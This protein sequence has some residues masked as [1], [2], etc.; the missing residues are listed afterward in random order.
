MASSLTLSVDAM[1]GDHA[2]LAI[3]DGVEL[4]AKANPGIKIL[5]HGDEAQ[6]GPL[7]ATRPH[8]QGASQLHHAGDVVP[9]DAKPSQAMRKKGT[10]M[11]NAIASVKAGHAQAAVSAGN[12][13]ALM[14]VAHLQLRTMD[15]LHRPA[16]AAAWPSPRGQSVVLDVGANVDSDPDQLVDF[17]IMGEAFASAMLGIEKPSIGLLNIGSEDVKGH[18]D[19]KEAMRLLRLHG[20]TLGLNVYGFVEGN[21]IS[22]G[23]TDVVVTDGFTGNVALKTAE[24]AARLVGMFLKEALTSGPLSMLGALLASGGLKKLKARMDPRTSNGGVFLGLNGLVVKSHGSTDGSGFA[25]AMGVAARLAASS[26]MDQIAENL[27]R[28]GQARSLAL[29][30]APSHLAE[31]PTVA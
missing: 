30:P 2:P 24:G 26:Y 10:S 20:S 15:G 8:A 31:E 12:T 27:Q 17:A 13:G 18:E 9:M 22:L 1:G 3:I 5:L 21:D 28:L 4:F 14:A 19:I 7:L 11:W 25:A 16:I 23:K 29:T 6:L